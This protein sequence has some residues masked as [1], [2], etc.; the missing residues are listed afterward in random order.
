MRRILLLIGL[1]SSLRVSASEL[2]IGALPSF[3]YRNG[4]VGLLRADA[5][6]LFG[7]DF[8][9][10]GPYGMYEGISPQVTDTSYGAA[11]RFGN[12][13]YFQLQGGFFHRVFSQ[14][15]TGTLNGKG[16]SAAL[17]GGWHLSPHLGVDVVL[18]SKRIESGTLGRRW[19]IDLL[20]LLTFRAELW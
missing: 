5:T 17:V 7:V 20:P 13:A 3:Q 15:G 6:L 18:S 10:L 11:L 2:Q 9:K 8:I 16:F 4:F 14:T 19:I 1:I 12:E